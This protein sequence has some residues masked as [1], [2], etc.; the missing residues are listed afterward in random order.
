MRI[1][2]VHYH[3]IGLKGFN[4]GA[5]ERRLQSNIAWALREVPGT[6]VVRVASRVLVRV[7]DEAALPTVAEALSRTPGVSYAAIGVS[8]PAEPDVIAGAALA[9]AREEIARRGSAIATFGVESRR[10]ATQ[11]P[12]P[13]L[14]IN[15]RV[16]EIIRS[17][18]GLK[19]DLSSPDLLVRIAVVQGS[20]YVYARRVEGPGGLPVG[21]SGKVV[22]L[23]SAGIDSPVAAWRIMR[24]GATV[25]G[26]HFSG[27]PQTAGASEQYAAEL[28]RVLSAG[29][30]LGRLYVVPFGDVQRAISLD[31]PPDLRV[32]LYR[33]FMVRVAEEIAREERAQALVTGESLGQVASQTLEN[34]AVVDA[35]ATLPVFRPLI[36][37]DKQEIVA[38]ARAL[39]T[40]DLSIATDDDC[41]T[42]FMPRRPQTHARHEEIAEGESGLDIPAL[43]AQAFAGIT[44]I[45]FPSASYRPPRK[46]R[47]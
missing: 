42:L 36:G 24:R 43:V 10:S 9:V 5:F 11:Y 26:A 4:R 28:C 47:R 45:D 40:Y 6:S 21:T 16:G 25:V 1:A 34:I 19:V 44:H 14:D 35:V 27:R 32:L 12:E 2:L 46:A 3:E 13:S 38:E 23:L 7:A 22:A 20:A 30:G 17:D 18:T 29:G 15:R 33:R 37:S 31:A 39:G 8:V 41:C